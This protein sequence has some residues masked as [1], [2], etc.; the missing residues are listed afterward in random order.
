MGQ[1]VTE[2]ISQGNWRIPKGSYT[3]VLTMQDGKPVASVID[4]NGPYVVSFDNVFFSEGS[5]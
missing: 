4:G 3:I 1:L 5:E 2:G